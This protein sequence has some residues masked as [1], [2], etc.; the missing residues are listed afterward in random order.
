MSIGQEELGP[1]KSMVSP[2]V[3]PPHA[4]QIHHDRTS[5]DVASSQYINAVPYFTARMLPG[6]LVHITF[7][8]VS[9]HN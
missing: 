3:C 2:A 6:I 1:Q 8:K 4:E 7:L 9:G 5:S